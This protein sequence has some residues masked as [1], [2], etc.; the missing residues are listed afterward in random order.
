MAE[1][2]S[3]SA[4]EGEP[5]SGPSLWLPLTRDENAASLRFRLD[6]SPQRSGEREV[7][8]RSIRCAASEYQERCH[9]RDPTRAARSVGLVSFRPVGRRS[10]V[11]WVIGTGRHS[12]ALVK[13][14]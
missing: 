14:A 2:G 6:L 4:V 9:V 7:K 11:V 13:L 12:A 1:R 3:V 10:G 8:R 5:C